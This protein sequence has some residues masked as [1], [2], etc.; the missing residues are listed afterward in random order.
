MEADLVLPNQN[1][2]A[3][4]IRDTHQGQVINP[5]RY[6]K[7]YMVGISILMCGFFFTNSVLDRGL[8]SSQIGR[9][10]LS[11]TSNIMLATAAAGVLIP[12]LVLKCLFP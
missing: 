10:A 8:V 7:I 12:M 6:I 1:P 4:N 11:T 2:N 3:N 9:M 5:D